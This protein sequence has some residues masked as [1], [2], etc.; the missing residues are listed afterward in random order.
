MAEKFRMNRR[1]NYARPRNDYTCFVVV[2][3]GQEATAATL[4]SYI[5]TPVRVK[6]NPRNDVFCFK[7]EH[8]FSLQKNS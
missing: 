3:V 5:R 1:K 8:F 6:S 2:G 4:A 7:K